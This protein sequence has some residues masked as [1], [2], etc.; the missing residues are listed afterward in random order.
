MQTKAKAV[1]QYAT[2]HSSVELES[3]WLAEL[4]SYRPCEDS[5]PVAPKARIEIVLGGSSKSTA[6]HIGVASLPSR[7]RHPLGDRRLRRVLDHSERHLTDGIALADLA[8]V[9]RAFSTATDM[10]LHRYVS[11]R[12]LDHAKEMLA[13]GRTSIAET[14]FTD[15]FSSQ[16]R[17][18]RAFRRTTVMT[19]AMY[20]RI[21]GSQ[22]LVQQFA[23]HEGRARKV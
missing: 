11:Q 12:R 21:R 14:A 23:S 16:S 5:D 6:T 10:R 17:F 20:R 3:T 13:A 8:N 15:R 7:S 22:V 1:P 4:R 18:T 9:M 2:L 19:P